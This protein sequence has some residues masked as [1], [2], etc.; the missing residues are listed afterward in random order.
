MKRLDIPPSEMNLI[1]IKVAKY[2]EDL[3]SKWVE[4]NR[5][6]SDVYLSSTILTLG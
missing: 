3:L 4:E 2:A 5:P 1:G 6:E